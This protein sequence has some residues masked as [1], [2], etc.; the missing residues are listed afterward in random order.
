MM[1]T[2]ALRRCA[3]AAGKIVRRYLEGVEMGEDPGD[4]STKAD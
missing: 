4:P 3:A 2:R 1:A